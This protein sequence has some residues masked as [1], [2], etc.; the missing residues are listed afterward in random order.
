MNAVYVPFR[1]P[2]EHLESFLNDVPAWN[3]HGLSVTI[4]HKQ[5]ILPMLTQAETAAQE[6]GAC[7][8]VVF[9]GEELLGYNTDY[10]AS[11]DCLTEA[12]TRLSTAEKPF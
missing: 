10:R 7:N 9:S 2:A 3:V 12:M 5:T 11:M 6:I 4:P 8:T 1:V